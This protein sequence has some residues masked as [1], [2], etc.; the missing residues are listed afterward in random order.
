MQTWSLDSEWWWVSH[1]RRP[2]FVVDAEKCHFKCISSQLRYKEDKNKNNVHVYSIRWFPKFWSINRETKVF[3][4]RSSSV[5]NWFPHTLCVFSVILMIQ[6]WLFFCSFYYFFFPK[7]KK[8]K[9][10]KF[11]SVILRTG[12]PGRGFIVQSF[13]LSINLQLNNIKWIFKF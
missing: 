3:K 10:L 9:H 8:K 4:S 5:C 7:K 12:K 2:Y 6:P 1:L 13:V 11:M